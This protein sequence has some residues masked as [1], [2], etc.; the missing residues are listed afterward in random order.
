MVHFEAA[1]ADKGGRLEI[2]LA[3]EQ[4]NI[5]QDL[6]RKLREWTGRTGWFPFHQKPATKQL[7]A[8]PDGGGYSPRGGNGRPSGQGRA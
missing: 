3:G 8:P 6:T 5:A 7:V 1:Q 2:R 4:A